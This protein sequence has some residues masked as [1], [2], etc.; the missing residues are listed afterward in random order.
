M[1]YRRI[2]KSEQKDLQ[3]FC[4]DNLKKFKHYNGHEAWLNKALEDIFSSNRKDEFSLGRVV[5]GAFESDNH[6]HNHHKLVGCIFLKLSQF[7]NSI[8]FKNIIVPDEN[9]LSDGQF[10]NIDILKMLVA[11]SIRFCEIRDI[12]KIEVELL[13][14]DYKIISVFFEHNFKVVATRE[15]YSPSTLVCILERRIGDNYFGDPFD[16]IQLGKWLLK[17]YIPSANQREQTENSISWIEFESKPISTAFSNQNKVGNE[18]RLRGR[19]WILEESE[20]ISPER[21]VLNDDIEYII[22][23]SSKIPQINLVLADY[24][25]N[26]QKAKLSK[27]NFISIDRSEAKEIAGGSYSSLNIPFD[28]NEVGGVITVLEQERI[29][30]FNTMNSLTY[31]LFSGVHS[32]LKF[33]DDYQINDGNTKL[34]DDEVL[35]DNPDIILL[36]ESWPILAVF[37]PSWTNGE[38]GI[39]GFFLIN[40]IENKPFNQLLNER[41]PVN[42]ALSNDDLKYYSTYSKRERIALLSCSKLFLFDKPLRILKKEW[43]S[44]DVIEDYISNEIRQGSNS[45]YMD[46]LSALNLKEAMIHQLKNKIVMFESLIAALSVLGNATQVAQFT[47]DQLSRLKSALGKSEKVVDN[48]LMQQLIRTHINDLQKEVDHYIKIVSSE[49]L[50]PIEKEKHM[51]NIAM[52]SIAILDLLVDF[53]DSVDDYDE[54]RKFLQ[55]I[56]NNRKF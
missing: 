52:K 55:S 40:K 15:K 32:G 20:D 2:R 53:K 6:I 24:L 25:S 56:I 46:N 37:C 4:L 21:K 38:V 7:D 29:L 10:S 14:D 45:M 30:H 19:F 48:N 12:E 1:L 31:Y 47:Q 33:D 41:V 16:N 13:Q 28:T 35:Y 54:L 26:D 9:I 44:K 5:I 22:D 51:V 39:A 11:K 18:K 23:E 34:D 17:Q 43:I 3:D 42:S 36:K 50:D 27:N 49:I 8:E